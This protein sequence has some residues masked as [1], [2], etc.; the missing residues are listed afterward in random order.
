MTDAPKGVK[1]CKVGRGFDDGQN[2]TLGVQTVT[3][4]DCE[5]LESN[6]VAVSSY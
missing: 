1:D 5:D 6:R 3:Y 2:E 4:E